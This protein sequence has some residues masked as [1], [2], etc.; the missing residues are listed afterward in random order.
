MNVISPLTTLDH[1]RKVKD[2][3]T[4][5]L[6]ERYQK[7]YNVDISRFT[8][9][10]D[11]I[12]QYECLDS[13]FLF[14]VPG[15][16]SGDDQFY[17]QLS[18]SK[19][20]YIDWK[21]EHE[22][23]LPYLDKSHKI[24]EIGCGKGG[25][26]RKLTRDGFDISGTELN[27]KQYDLLA[28]EGLTIYP[29]LLSRHKTRNI[30]Y[31]DIVSFQVLEH[32]D[33]PRSFILDSLA[34]L[35]PGGKFIFCVPNNDSFI[36]DDPNLILNMPPHHMGLWTEDSIKA[37]TKLFPLTLETI[38]FEPLQPH[39]HMHYLKTRSLKWFGDKFFRKLILA[40]ILPIGLLY[41]R[42][43]SSRIRG[44]SILAVYTKK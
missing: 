19:D 42:L 7:R 30:T 1:T 15:G 20:Y 29:D 28:K 31:D 10:L 36:K 9:G 11:S 12:S 18:S 2:I 5:W 24:L 17:Q 35:R 14:F 37:I 38:L 22:A 13:G 16:I 32:I 40:A 21:W 4:D 27:S 44:Q 41:L 3:S 23:A 39:H 26:L 33:N 25:F 8:K 6:K 43:F 34:M